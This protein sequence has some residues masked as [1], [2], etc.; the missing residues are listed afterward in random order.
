MSWLIWIVFAVLALGWTGLSWLGASG[1]EW[2]GG[3]LAG[4]GAVDLAGALSSWSLP[5]WLVVWLDLGWLQ[6]MQMFFV[7]VMESLREAWPWIG[8]A[9]GWLVP[10]IWIVWGLGMALLLLLAVLGHWLVRRGSGPGPSA[11]AQ[12]RAA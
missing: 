4:G 8:A 3:Q 7:D 11:P 12:P 6:S 9:V 2:V 5:T 1:L 10:L